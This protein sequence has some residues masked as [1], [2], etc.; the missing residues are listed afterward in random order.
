MS[1]EEVIAVGDA[2]RRG[3]RSVPMVDIGCEFAEL[4]DAV[5]LDTV[6]PDAMHACLK[7]DP[8]LAVTVAAITADDL[9]A[10]EFLDDVAASIAATCLIEE[11]R[12]ELSAPAWADTGVAGVQ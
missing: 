2:A 3:P 9:R 1:S 11:L 12:G 6:A 5:G 8:L 7:P 10:L 4:L